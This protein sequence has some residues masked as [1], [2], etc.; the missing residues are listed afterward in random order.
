LTVK[1]K[2]MDVIVDFG[3]KSMSLIGLNRDLPFI[4]IKA[5][6]V[7]FSDNVNVSSSMLQLLGVNV[8][9]YSFSGF[10]YNPATFDATWS[11]PTA[12]GVDRLMLSLSGEQ[13]PPVSGSGPNIGADPFSNNFSV[14]PGDVDGDG[15]VSASDMVIERNEIISGGYLIWADVDGN[16]VVDLTDFT[17]VRKRLGSHLP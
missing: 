1:P 6:D 8:P 17:N 13:A 3:S 16:G 12:I 7:I 11:L 10:S 2:V 9:N 4:N 15:V 5:L 14:L